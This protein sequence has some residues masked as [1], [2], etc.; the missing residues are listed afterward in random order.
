[1]KISSAT[2][3]LGVAELRGRL[4]HYLKQAHLGRRLIVTDH[5]EPVAEL[6]PCNRDSGKNGKTDLRETLQRLA[7]AGFMSY[8][9]GAK[10]GKFRKF[11]PVAI[12]TPGECLASK[13]LAK[14]REDSW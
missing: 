2:T 13:M 1:M 12:G 9:S 5:G 11:K 10:R 3:R 6:V 7:D 14:D 8:T 4:S